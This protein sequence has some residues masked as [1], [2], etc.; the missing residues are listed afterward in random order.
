VKEKLV[1]IMPEPLEEMLMALTVFAQY[2]LIRSVLGRSADAPVVVYKR[3]QLHGLIRSCWPTTI[4]VVEPT[5]QQLDEADF[6]HEFDT[7]S[8]YRITEAVEK[9]IGESF[10]IRLGAHMMRLLPPVLVE[11]EREEIG[12]VLLAER[13]NMDG[14][15][16]SWYWPHKEALWEQLLETKIPV[17]FLPKDADWEILRTAVG[18]S[19]V[20]IG[21]RSSVTL[22]AAA[23]NRVVIELAPVDKGHKEWF[24]KPECQ[25][26]R[27]L[28]G[29]LEDMTSIFVWAQVDRL[30]RSVKGPK[31]MEPVGVEV[32]D[33]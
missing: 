17:Q 32:V 10:A 11:D 21:P 22:L 2:M 27:M 8:T 24:R 5:R 20:V 19:S 3:E 29:R 6:V 28:R 15:D 23:A 13:N 4:A 7:E 26:Y 9:P 31:K 14:T 16:E 33:V 12:M 18:R 30:I 25:T 1:F